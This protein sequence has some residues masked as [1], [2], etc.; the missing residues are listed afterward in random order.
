MEVGQ[1]RFKFSLLLSQPYPTPPLPQPL[2]TPPFPPEPPPH[3]FGHCCFFFV[4]FF[5]KGGHL[6]WP[7]HCVIET[8]EVP[9]CLREKKTPRPAIAGLKRKDVTSNMCRPDTQ[10]QQQQQRLLVNMNN[11]A[12]I[13][14]Q[15]QKTFCD[16]IS[17]SLSSFLF[18]FQPNSFYF[19]LGF[20]PQ[21]AGSHVR[22]TVSKLPGVSGALFFLL[23]LY[24][25]FYFFIYFVSLL[26]PPAADLGLG[27]GS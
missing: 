27:C 15:R 12:N 7:P 25:V 20:R 16:S 11:R 3:P 6:Y 8:G 2:T 19:W 5:L 4:V 26:R 24:F 14:H 1:L 17:T 23:F 18:F 22:P 9:V 10:Q 21:L 13:T